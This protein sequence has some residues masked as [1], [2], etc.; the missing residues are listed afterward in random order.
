[1]PFHD[2]TFIQWPVSNARL[3]ADIGLF[4]PP[5]APYF[6]YLTAHCPVLSLSA[7]HIKL[8]A[9]VTSLWRSVHL[10]FN[11]AWPFEHYAHKLRPRTPLQTLF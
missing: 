2:L 11:V 1:V 5:G 9:V 6:M 7:A 10:L 8:M 4:T 3:M